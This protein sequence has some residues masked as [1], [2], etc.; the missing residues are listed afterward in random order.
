M[1]SMPPTVATA[2]NIIPIDWRR[3]HDLSDGNQEFEVEL[4][5]IF[6]VETK[7]QLQVLSL[8][9]LESDLPTIEHLAHK[10]KGSSG[11]IGLFDLYNT[12]VC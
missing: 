9:I 1:Y 6:F 4:L 12:L 11:N 10:L 8:A 3:L 5:K 2:A 7:T